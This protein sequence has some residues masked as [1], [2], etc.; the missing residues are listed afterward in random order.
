MHAYNYR[1]EATTPC[2]ASLSLCSP[3]S[4]PASSSA[5]LPAFPTS[6]RLVPAACA[7][8]CCFTDPSTSRLTSLAAFSLHSSSLRCSLSSSFLSFLLC[9][10][11]FD[12]ILC[13][14]VAVP[15]DALPLAHL[16]LPADASFPPNPTLG[17]LSGFLQR[18]VL[19][20]HLRSFPC[21][22]HQWINDV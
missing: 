15:P 13:L 3:P 1:C 22:P 10:C 6:F 19:A 12:G 21:P 11:R 4:T 5:R 8:C 17:A 7:C 14:P 2:D 16:A 9:R 20:A 18:E